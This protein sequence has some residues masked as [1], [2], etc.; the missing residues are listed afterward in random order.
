MLAQCSVQ[1]SQNNDL[2]FK[3][4]WWRG[5]SLY[6]F[7]WWGEVPETHLSNL[8]MREA[9]IVT[10]TNLNCTLLYSPLS[11]PLIPSSFLSFLVK[12]R[13]VTILMHI[14]DFFS[15]KVLK[16]LLSTMPFFTILFLTFFNL[17]RLGITFLGVCLFPIWRHFL[18]NRYQAL[19]NLL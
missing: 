12:T 17:F 8:Q 6:W 13:L 1:Q 7:L 19:F 9:M 4:V 2:Q 18:K 14:K 10:S 3:H 15:T 16:T 5:Q 11:L